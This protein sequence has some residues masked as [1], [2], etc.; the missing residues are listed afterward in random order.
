MV[1]GKHERSHPP[2]PK[3]WRL[4]EL[5]KNR[6]NGRGETD[7]TNLLRPSNEGIYSGR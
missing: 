4:T 5:R 2:L 1:F 6:P 3:Y 7:L